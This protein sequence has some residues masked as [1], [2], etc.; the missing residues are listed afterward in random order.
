MEGG[1]IMTLK[2]FTAKNKFDVEA[3]VSRLFP[4]LTPYGKK[5]Y[6]S[7]IL[8]Y[9]FKK[10]TDR[11]EAYPHKP[12]EWNDFVKENSKEAIKQGKK[13]KELFPYLSKLK[14]SPTKEVLEKLYDIITSYNNYV[15]LYNATKLDND[16]DN[17]IKAHKELVEVAYAFEKKYPNYDI[18]S[19]GIL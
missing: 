19:S 11:R 1:K 8:E 4:T 12:N 7:I 14:N 3:R 9:E 10:L 17:M 18:S 5:V 6:V 13:G 2:G 16:R 15:A